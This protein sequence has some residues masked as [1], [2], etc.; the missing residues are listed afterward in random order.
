MVGIQ[1]CYDFKVCKSH[2]PKPLGL[3]PVTYKCDLVYPF[4][5]LSKL[6]KNTAYYTIYHV[7]SEQFFFHTDTEI[8]RILALQTLSALDIKIQFFGRNCKIEELLFS[9]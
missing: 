8:L 1:S 5:D 4:P 3:G 2:F 6:K 7:Y 9:F